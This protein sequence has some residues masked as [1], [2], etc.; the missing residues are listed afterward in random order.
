[1]F[2]LT[3]QNRIAPSI[4]AIFALPTGNMFDYVSDLRCS[5]INTG[6]VVGA[7]IL[8]LA[9]SAIVNPATPVSIQMSHMFTP[10]AAAAIVALVPGPPTTAAAVA[11]AVAAVRA[12][13]DNDHLISL[14]RSNE[15]NCAG[16]LTDLVSAAKK[17]N[18]SN[19]NVE[20]YFASIGGELVNAGPVAGFINKV[21]VFCF[22]MIN[23]PAFR[24][25]L[26]NTVWTQYRI[27]R[28]AAGGI[29]FKLIP[30][31]TELGIL[32]PGDED[33]I[34]N[35]A[36]SPWDLT[37]ASLIRPDLKGIAALYLEAAGTPIDDWYQGSKAIDEMPSVRVKA[38]KKAFKIYLHL[39][40]DIGDE[41]DYDT[42]AAVTAVDSRI[43][44]LW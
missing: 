14:I 17:K 27:S 24:G 29:L 44:N 9:K 6:A 1:M 38:I 16:W 33:A 39:K 35:S 42:L 31:F 30:E 41:T 13:T 12:P 23:D 26:S 15:T 25:L 2:G 40:I 7:M 8:V 19:S 5:D 37:L 20:G 3:T 43:T 18:L 21:K 4:G 36:A 22:D 28:V 11:A 32:K 34:R 10:G